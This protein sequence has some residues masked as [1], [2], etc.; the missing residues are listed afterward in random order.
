MLALAIRE[1]VNH[2]SDSGRVLDNRVE[3]VLEHVA[4]NIANV[5][6]TDNI[7]FDSAKF[8]EACGLTG[9]FQTTY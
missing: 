5:C 3:E 9:R 1:E 6:I 2:W 4:T 8:Y 7:R